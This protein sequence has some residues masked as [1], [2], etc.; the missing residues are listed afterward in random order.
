V[1][2]KVSAPVQP[3]LPGEVAPGTGLHAVVFTGLTV[4]PYVSENG[5]RARLAYSI[6]A[7]EMHGQGK[8]PADSTPQTG[9]S[10][11]LVPSDAPGHP[12]D[13]KAA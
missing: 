6:R 2:V 1:T 13:G 11:G 9:R 8:A 12:G 10:G 3:V 4:T 7:T 5:G